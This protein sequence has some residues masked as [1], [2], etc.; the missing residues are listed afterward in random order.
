VGCQ[1]HGFIARRS[2]DGGH[3][4]SLGRKKVVVKLD[5]IVEAYR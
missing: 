3:C 2:A 4:L 5:G 1:N